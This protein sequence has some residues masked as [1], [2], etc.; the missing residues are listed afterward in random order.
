MNFQ[1]IENLIN[2]LILVSKGEIQKENLKEA[3]IPNYTDS[4]G[5]GCFHF[6]TEYSFEKFCI[7]NIELNN[8]QEIIDFNNYI[9]I[10]NQYIQQINSFIEI[11]LYLNCDIISPNKNKEN[12]L[13]LSIIK[14][15]YI[16]SKEYFKIQENLGIY[17]E[18]DYNNILNLIINNGN[19][20]EQDCIELIMM[21]I[22]ICDQNKNNIFNKALLN[23]VNKEFELTPLI[24]L[25]KNF[26]DNIYLN[27]NQIIKINAMKYI[28][29]NKNMQIDQNTINIIKKESFE[30]IKKYI[31]N[32]FYP[33][34]LQIINLGGN[35]QS[36]KISGFIYLMSFPFLE[37][38]SSFIN[39][40]KININYQDNMG[41]TALIYL[42]NN[43]ENI[44]QISKD[45]YYNAF[46]SLISIDNIEISKCDNNGE[47]G[48][49]I[50]LEKEYF[51]DAKIIFEKFKNT[52]I[53]NF[54]ADILVFIINCLKEYKNLS[55]I[56][57]FFKF[58]EN[59]IDFN[60]YNFQNERSLLH[61][62]CL[63]LSDNNIKIDINLYKEIFF[64]L[65]NL[66]IDFSVKD[67]F[68][69]NFLFYLF[70]SE[71]DNIKTIDPFKELEYFLTNYK[72][73][74][75]ND[76]DIFG[77]NL[78]FYAIQSKAFNCI[79]ILL[80]AGISFDISQKNNE[81][82]IYSLSLLIGDFKL[83]LYFYNKNKNPNIFNHKVYESY[84]IKN[85]K[86][87]IVYIEEKEETLYDFLN[88][89]K[90]FKSKL[91][92]DVLSMEQQNKDKNKNKIKINQNKINLK[93]E[94]NYFNFIRNDILQIIEQYT[95]DITIKII[96]NNSDDN[97]FNLFNINEINNDLKIDDIF[98]NFIKKY[99]DYIYERINTERNIIS[100]NL[101]R[102]C[103][104]KNYEQLCKFMIDEKYNL[105]SICNDL[106]ALHKFNDINECIKKILSDNNNDQ[107]KLINLKNEKEQTI[108][109]ILSN[110]QNNLFFC[111]NLEN[112]KI[113]NLFDKD[114][115]TPMY[116]ACLNFNIIFIETFSHY[117]F[118]LSDNNSDVVNYGL[119]LETK[120]GKTPLEILYEKL[121][122]NDEK[123]I[124]II[125]DISTN[126]KKVYFIPVIKYLIQSYNPINNRLFTIHYKKNF[127]SI[128]YLRKIIGLFQFYTKELNGSIMLKDED[129]NDP[130]FICALNNNYDFLFNIL[131]EEHNISLNTTNNKGKSIIHLIV[132]LSGYLN[133]YKE[134]LLKQAIELGF[135]FNVKDNE[136]MLPIDYAY[137]EEDYNIVNI[138][139]NYYVNFGLEVPKNKKIKPINTINYN[140]CK[141]SD[142]FYNESILVSAKIDKFENLNE[143]ISKYF[144]YDPAIEY[145]QICLDEESIPYSVN[146]VKKDFINFNEN[147]EKQF[148]IQ[149]LK[150]CLKENNEYILIT[151]DNKK[152]NQFKYNNFQLAE[153]KFREIFREKTE[154]DW[155]NIKHNKSNFK[156]NYLQNYIF[157]Y[158]YEEE[159]AIY[160]YL[161]ITIKNLYI[162]KKLEFKG[163]M[164]IK[165][166]IYY[167]T[168][169]AYKNRFSIDEKSLKVEE[170]TRNIIEKYKK[171]AIQ[172]AID[173]LL[174]IK[175]LLNERNKDEI[176]FKKRVYLINSYNDLIPYSHKSND[177]NLFDDPKTID[178]EISR[179]TTY[180][181]IENILK[182]FL[183]SIYNLNKIHPLDYIINSLGCKIIEIPKPQNM[184]HLITEGD[185]IYNY[186]YSTG[187]GLNTITAIYKITQSIHDK[188]FNLKNF[189]NRF[190]FCH[191]TK[192]ENIIGILSQGLKI[193]PVQAVNTGKAYGNGIYLSDLFSY[194]LLY[195]Y[196]GNQYVPSTKVFMLLVE[197]AVGKIGVME[198]TDVVRMSVN[199]DDIFMTNEGYGIFKN[200]NKI[201]YGTGIIV[202]HD[203][204]NV[205]I[206]YIVEIN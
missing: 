100:E 75:L 184:E 174:D 55:K 110:V 95:K 33:L 74:N 101:F 25:C 145:Y 187:A 164:K 35:L 41:N 105:I 58:F 120:N 181:Y 30:E 193:A 7:R 98:S 90:D 63:Y 182:I 108:Y 32:Y 81:N 202:A 139:I 94:F 179:L 149:I 70:L 159:N 49:Y 198:D 92:P 66:K 4:N 116:Y 183:G 186:L 114:G 170:N 1:E 173:I 169:K 176:Y 54:N 43:K 88:T 59:L 192:V 53:L 17:N 85:N 87:I 111:K 118:S 48:F 196:P 31:N 188:N 24:S 205:R 148:C 106:I 84:E 115:N 128:D 130:F 140:F 18:N 167:L 8:N 153:K 77:N 136:D 46:N 107:N 60:L 165:N 45:I 14:G 144:K 67:Q 121:N 185:Y 44:I 79:N 51:D 80:N 57:N 172:K 131:L 6:L 123:V 9:D 113:S 126:M 151:V 158:T 157:D 112:H 171:T 29:N 71:N 104:L 96:I 27:Y 50:C 147:N 10:K 89:D 200:S 23:K 156:N 125:I 16:L 122:K 137:L 52:N 22:S 127:L 99:D 65:Y 11:L 203:E 40:Q 36:N 180:Y 103:L 19:C 39:E 42:I 135:D 201:N 5:N 178:N 168:V 109:H 199:F 3:I 133:T 82:S 73:D 119:F 206:K 47:S 72:L 15:N 76:V 61:Y 146:L 155:D 21:V 129:G 86:D 142:N 190:I 68:K 64:F 34:F 28:N 191:G 175:K 161:K 166:L 69:R 160:D 162:K 195:C 37:N 91:Y 26:D 152:L 154:N 189:Q 204:T 62:I 197:V 2:S 38:I 78:L 13:T 20:F 141:D 56:K 138:L 117:S 194:S 12:P 124:K 132:E 143:P 134:G 177:F 102:Y 97:N 83:F 93:K 150:D 163:N